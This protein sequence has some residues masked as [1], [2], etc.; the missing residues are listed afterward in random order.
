MII[1]KASYGVPTIINAEATARGF[2]LTGE[3]CHSNG[4][5]YFITACGHALAFDR[6]N[7]R[8]HCCK[9]LELELPLYTRVA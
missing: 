5:L 1:R 3:A 8:Y 9:E 7:S 4:L 6:R 2:S